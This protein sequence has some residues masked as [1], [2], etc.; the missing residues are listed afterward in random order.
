M[1]HS[2]TRTSVKTLTAL[3]AVG[4]LFAFLAPKG[5]KNAVR[6]LARKCT[7]PHW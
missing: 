2:T 3:T 7:G 4:G 1:T 6:S 5:A